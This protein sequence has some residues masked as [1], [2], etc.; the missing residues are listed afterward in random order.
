MATRRDT[1]QRKLALHRE[2]RENCLNGTYRPGHL[3]PPMK[4]LAERY[5]LSI[6]V[7]Q[8]AVHELVAEGIIYTVPGVGT[9]AGRRQP[10]TTEYYLWLLE[11][12]PSPKPGPIQIGFEERIAHLGGACLP[13]AGSVAAELHDRNELPRLAGVYDTG[14]A[15]G[16]TSVWE[17]L[18][19]VPRVGFA[20]HIQDSSQTDTV[21]FDDL[22]G[23]RQ[24]AKHLLNAGF[25]RIAFLSLSGQNSH[26]E[27][28]DWARAREEGWRQVLEEAR[29]SPMGMAFHPDQEPSY[30]D[31]EMIQAGQAASEA[32]LKR[33]DID[34]VVAANDLAALGMI[35]ALC[36]AQVPETHWPAIVGFDNLPAA[37]GRM[38]TSL[39]LPWEEIGRTAA[40]LLW[41]RRNGTLSGPPVHRYVP[42]RLL[43]RLTSR[44]LPASGPR[45]R[46]GGPSPVRARTRGV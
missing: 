1:E 28:F 19:G 37:N 41:A 6:N 3:L 8:R 5:S 17:I 33:R 46:K 18:Q 30:R 39:R 45:S 22:D 15:T 31:E 2:V 13:L 16:N 10:D 36:D 29:F 34:A 40:D 12:S 32:I 7:A 35:A 14:Q 9:F 26:T 27:S 11:E 21:R 4:E 44:A 23:G 25:Q 43:P 38:L 42:M 20:P 24:A